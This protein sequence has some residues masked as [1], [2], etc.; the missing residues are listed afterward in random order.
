MVKYLLLIL[1][2]TGCDPFGR[3]GLKKA[4]KELNEA[5]CMYGFVLALAEVKKDKSVYII[6]NASRLTGISS[7]LCEKAVR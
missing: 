6:K 5:Y 2:L 7:S 1:L 4:R 3:R